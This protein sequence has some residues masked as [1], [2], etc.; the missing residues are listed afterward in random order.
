MA[1]GPEKSLGTDTP[2]HILCNIIGFEAEY[3][4]FLAGMDEGIRNLH[5]DWY[6]I[7]RLLDEN[8]EE[9]TNEM[10]LKTQFM[11]LGFTVTRS[12]IL[13]SWLDKNTF[14]AHQTTAYFAQRYIRSVFDQDESLG[15]ITS[16]PLEG[17]PG[18]LRYRNV[19][20][21]NDTIS[22]VKYIN[23]KGHEMPTLE[24]TFW[25]HGTDHYSALNI[26]DSG[27]ELGRGNEKQDFSDGCGF[28]MSTNLDYAKEWAEKS[29]FLS[30]PALVVFKIPDNLFAKYDGITFTSPEDKWH[31]IVM[32][33]R[34]GRRK[35]KTPLEVKRIFSVDFIEGPINHVNTCPSL[36]QM[37]I[38]S[39]GLAEVLSNPRFIEYVIF[40][41][42]N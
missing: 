28:Y 4:D 23:L 34:S 16:Y 9:L 8:A 29:T 3:A 37:C 33:N 2:D 40:M 32:Y 1:A 21:E 27:I 30:V 6:W 41:S 22:R 15:N 13:S 17:E 24:E 38:L 7:S 14:K 11:A 25:F 10:D 12:V 5:T 35:C 39:N 36:H 19:E 26:L 42:P 20:E 18:E 31:D